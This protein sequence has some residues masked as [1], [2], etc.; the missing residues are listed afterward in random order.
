MRPVVDPQIPFQETF[1]GLIG[2]Q[3]VE[4]TEDTVTARI[5]VGNRHRQSF[6]VVHGGVYAAMAEGL[7]SAAT[8]QAHGGEKLVMGSSNHTSFLRPVLEGTV[9][10]E[11]RAKHSGRTTAVWEVEFRNG[12]GKLCALARVT[13]AI[14]DSGS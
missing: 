6:G 4:M 2:P 14:R 10:A 7:C 9:T 5:E 1:D 13:L 8:W 11:G 12:E 3:D